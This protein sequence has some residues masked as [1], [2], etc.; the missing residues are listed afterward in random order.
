VA[1]RDRK[2]AD[3]DEAQLLE[4]SRLL[5]AEM[6][7]LTE[8]AKALVASYKEVKDRLKEKKKKTGE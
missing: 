3:D 7:R 8:R 2:F 1:G 6:E 5:I 4:R